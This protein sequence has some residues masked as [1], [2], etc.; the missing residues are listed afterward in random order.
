MLNL[1]RNLKDRLDI[2]ACPKCH[3]N[4]E[5]T[6]DSL[7]C[8]GCGEIFAVKNGKI[9]FSA[10]P[11]HETQ[12]GDVKHWLRG[13]FGSYYKSA[14]WLFG[15]GLSR[16]ARRLLL[17]N[18]DPTTCSVIDLGSGVERIH[19]DVITFDLFDYPE[20][21]IVCNLDALPFGI[22][23]VDAFVT[24]SV[25]EHVED[26]PALIEMMHSCTKTDGIGIHSF[27]FLFPFHEAP[28][29]FVRYTHMGAMSLFKKWKIQ[30]LFNSA[31][32]V[33]LINTMLAE[34]ISTLFSFGN[35]KIKEI[36]H[37]M[38]S[39]LIFPFKF[40]DLLFVNRPRF[41]PV[42]AILC[43]VVKKHQ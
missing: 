19:P 37:L 13:V 39:M 29:D 22:G 20:V 1:P 9:Y 16:N 33:T 35:G 24:S 38:V 8:I 18:I 41:M 5:K 21:D 40:I 4:L 7:I 10:V 31:G 30:R 42:S 23:K 34:F 26:V 3:Q 28:Y 6:L 11:A 2:L 36:L 12:S 15:P 17:E 32:P 27:P 43:I 25:L 14:V